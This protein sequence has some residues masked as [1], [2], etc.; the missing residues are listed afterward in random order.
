MIR[1]KAFAKLNLS[2]EVRG[3]R[4]DGY[5][6]LDTIMQSIDLYDIVMIKKADSIR[7]RFDADS[8]NERRNTAYSAAEVFFS[9]TG[10]PGGTRE[11]LELL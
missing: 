8:I 7:V 11:R 10:I 2:L 6:E 4:P 3:Q 5:H 1:L 9:H